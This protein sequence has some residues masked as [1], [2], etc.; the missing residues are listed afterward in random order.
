MKNWQCYN[1][2]GTSHYK[3][4]CETCS[5][6]FCDDCLYIEHQGENETIIA[7][8]SLKLLDK[9]CPCCQNMMLNAEHFCDFL[10]EVK[11]IEY[12]ELVDEYEKYKIINKIK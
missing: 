7:S 11:Q 2:S 1:C 4:E 9:F 6:L 8:D 3:R 5:T 12:F 10:R